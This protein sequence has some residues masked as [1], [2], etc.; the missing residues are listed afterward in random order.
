MIERG[1]DSLVI[2][3]KQ[4]IGFIEVWMTHEEQEQYD[5]TELTRQI[6]DHYQP[7]KKCMIAFYLSGD[8]D[9]EDQTKGLLTM[10]L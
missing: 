7:E 1:T 9:L 2:Q 10:N 5:R 6:L 3:N 8:R 4:D